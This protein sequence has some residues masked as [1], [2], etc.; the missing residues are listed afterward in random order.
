M[1]TEADKPTSVKNPSSRPVSANATKDQAVRE[2]AQK[3]TFA[4]RSGDDAAMKAS[5]CDLIAG[6]RDALPVFA[7]EIRGQLQELAGPTDSLEKIGEVFVGGDFAAVKTAEIEKAGAC[8]ILFFAKTSAGWRSWTLRNAPLDAKLKDLLAKEVATL[9]GAFKK[10]GNAFVD[11]LAA[12]KF[13]DATAQFADVLRNA[14]PEAKLA[15][16]WHQLEG[17]GGKFLGADPAV[18][19]ERNAEFFCVYVPCRWERNRLDLKVVFD[20]A[21]KV[22]G[23]WIVPATKPEAGNKPV[24][25]SEKP[26][27]AAAEAWQALVDGGKYAESWKAAA[28]IFQAGVT[29]QAWAH[30][31]ETF[32]KPLGNL[33]S[34]KM[35]STQL[36]KEMP[37][38]PDGKYV[39]MQFDTS[40]AAQK[41]VV[42][43]VTFLLEKDGQWKAAG[44]FIK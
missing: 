3:L 22:S 18:R 31:M 15:E 12:G 29:E 28:A 36:V 42:E 6:W 43:T 10:R 8:L 4:M 30:S 34:R 32:R 35:T 13:P 17:A 24:D 38:A 20:L 33:I 1:R 21:G 16:L 40:F 39:V 37:G 9:D 27:A 19:I 7:K 2:V 11:L 44:Y 26:A 5:A 41:T 23:L 14:M 25:E